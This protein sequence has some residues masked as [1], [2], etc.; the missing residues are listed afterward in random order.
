MLTYFF[1]IKNV[2]DVFLETKKSG[3]LEISSKHLNLYGAQTLTELCQTLT[4]CITGNFMLLLNVIRSY[5][6]KIKS[7]M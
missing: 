7:R 4:G 1:T 2:I 3:L 6:N 5:C